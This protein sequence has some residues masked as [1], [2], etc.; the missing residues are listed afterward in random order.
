MG[1]SYDKDSPVIVDVFPVAKAEMIILVALSS[2][3]VICGV[4]G[5]ITY[6]L[7][8]SNV[9]VSSILSVP[10]VTNTVAEMVAINCMVSCAVNS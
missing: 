3:V 1:L 6:D 10:S 7:C 8:G 9:I 5:S 4:L 2:V